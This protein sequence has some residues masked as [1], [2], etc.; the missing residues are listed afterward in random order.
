MVLE[1]DQATPTEGSYDSHVIKQEEQ[2]EEDEGEFKMDCYQ[3]PVSLLIPHIR[4]AYYTLHVCVYAQVRF[5]QT[6]RTWRRRERRWS[7]R[8]KEN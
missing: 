1:G 7:K 4:H 8:K 3:L 6:R 2:E 5:I